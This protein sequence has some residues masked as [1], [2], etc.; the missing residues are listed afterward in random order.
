MS[1]YTVTTSA[2][3]ME[4][5][6]QAGFLLPQEK[7][8]ALQTEAGASLLFS[9]GTGG[10]FYLTIESPGDTN[11]WRQVDLGAARIIAD[12]GG[13]ARV[14]TFG[15]AQAPPARAGDAAQIHLGMVLSDGPNDH[16]YLSLNNSD[17]DLG[18]TG[19]PAWTAVPFNA[20]NDGVPVPPPSPLRIVNVMIGEATDQEYI[21]VDIVRNPGQDADF[22]TRYYIDTSTPSAPRWTLHDLATDI[23][24]VN[25]DSCLGR[26]A[27]N[28]DVDGIYTKGFVGS[29]AQLSYAPV[30]NPVDPAMPP[31]P[32]LL[33]LPGGLIADAI[34]AARNPDNTSDLYVAAEGGLYWFASTNQRNRA[35]GILVAS[36]PLLGAVR[37]L[38]ACRADGSVT[39]WG[40]N[41]DD[42]VFYLTCPA[43]RQQTPA[44]WNV[45]L[46][47]LA[48]VD[49]I[50]PFVDRN[51]SANTFFAHSGAGLVKVVKSPTTGLWSSRNITLPPAAAK[52]ATP[53][54]SYTTRIQV[55]GAD[56]QPATDVPV[57]LTATNVTSVYVNHLY[58]LIGP[59]PV[60]L[61]TDMLGS[62]TIVEAT[63]SLTATRYQ[64]TVG[65][66]EPIAVNTMDTAWQRNARYTTTGSLQAAKI[67][68]RDG[69]TRDFVPAG[70]SEQALDGVAQANQALAAAYDQLSSSPA[71][72]VAGARALAEPAAVT[73]ETG[74]TLQG[75]L[76][77]V[78]DLFSWLASTDA[79]TIVNVFKDAA[80]NA[81]YVITTI[82]DAVY[83]AALDCLEA[84]AAA[85]TW[86]YN[87]IKIAV[88]DI[89]EFLEFIFGWQDILVTHRVLK[90]MFLCLGQSAIDGID[91]A[92]DRVRAL[93]AEIQGQ[94]NGWAGIPDFPQTASATLTGS[95]P[96]DGLHSAPANLG[97]H[98]FQGNAAAAS[99]DLSLLE[100]A[101]EI[102]K[103]LVI[104]LAAEG[105]TVSNLVNAI[106]SDIIDQ[107][108]SLSVTDVITK[109][110]AIAADTA[111]QSTENVL[112]TVLDVFGQLINGM[113]GVLT[114]KLDIPVLG[115][116]YYDLTGDDLSFLDVI[117]LVAAIP[118]TIVYKAA[119]LAVTQTADAPFPADDP[120]T[121]GLLAAKDWSGI[122]AQFRRTRPA[123]RFAATAADDPPGVIPV[124]ITPAMEQARLK[125]FGFTAGILTRVGTSI[126]GVVTTIQR[127]FAMA[128]ANPPKK[129]ALTLAT[130]ACGGN[131]LYVSP[132]IET[133]VQSEADSWYADVNSALTLASIA[134]GLA[135]IPCSLLTNPV[136]GQAFGLAETVLNVL[137]M[138]P[139]I[140]NI[141][142]N[143]DIWNTTYKAL[144]PESIGD[145]CFNLGGI[146]EWPIVLTKDPETLLVLAGT[147]AGLMS[148]YSTCYIIAGGIYQFA[149]DQS[150]Y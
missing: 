95:K 16:L 66:Q 49:A 129:A 6:I 65:S 51:Y 11:G 83:H 35:T 36:S 132:N 21:V 85:A 34:A 27:R 103:D 3:L 135:A 126:L 33:N 82:G 68:N 118:A 73:L 24:A 46:P 4:N 12:F 71:P 108:A 115:W 121:Q 41:G 50:S 100:P 145:F 123:P 80:R 32:S 15:A 134:K 107:F 131:V 110:L 31:A 122:Q 84:V 62:I 44:A 74:D 67:V 58:Y 124:V 42:Q 128:D 19:Q 146:L 45:P 38:Y 138:V 97:I 105:D 23:R 96:P 28:G 136:V 69:S 9:I 112:V 109:F 125:K 77:D 63:A 147:Q 137:W 1:T 133:I 7:F 39:V 17:S 78:G 75:V 89:L 102:L 101:E 92:K 40:I 60:H 43:G 148:T 53:I 87:A 79:E 52:P 106:K 127:V 56:G 150:N 119:T 18:W 114:E 140:A 98:H 26:A 81:W 25:D 120:F 91:E 20:M 141:Y 2:E 149:P 143:K 54:H 94:I 57:T 76:V 99:S 14:K 93:S 111:L 59:S 130:I 117:C 61:T 64:V 88:E 86:V 139:P 8:S 13:R 47:I 48:G 37:N 113:M 55:T 5:Y 144:I 72:P 142:Y 70:T 22:I 29:S 10:V 30:R 116:L 104:L 90:N